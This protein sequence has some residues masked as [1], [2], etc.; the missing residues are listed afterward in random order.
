MKP[1]AFVEIEILSGIDQIEAR[2]PSDNPR[3]E[4]KWGQ[5]DTAALRDPGSNRRDR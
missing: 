5:I 3:G 4:N 2:N 1:F